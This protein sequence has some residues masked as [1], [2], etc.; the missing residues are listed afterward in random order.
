[1]N[2]HLFRVFTIISLALV[3]TLSYNLTGST[4]EPAV[5]GTDGAPLETKTVQM[6]SAG[7]EIQIGGMTLSVGASNIPAP[8]A[9]TLSASGFPMIADDLAESVMAGGMIGARAGWTKYRLR[10]EWRIHA[11]G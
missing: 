9:L 11:S 5:S 7:G 6:D 1:M 8:A 10:D 2:R 4:G 3:I